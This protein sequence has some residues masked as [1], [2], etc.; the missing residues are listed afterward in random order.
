MPTSGDLKSG[1]F[2]FFFSHPIIDPP[3]HPQ[4]GDPHPKKKWQIFVAFL[5]RS[6]NA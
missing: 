3:T 4:K 6:L 1:V 2:F 5:L